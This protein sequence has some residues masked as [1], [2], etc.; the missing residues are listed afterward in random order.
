MC[1]KSHQH[2]RYLLSVSERWI[3]RRYCADPLIVMRVT[4]TVDIWCHERACRSPTAVAFL[5]AVAGSESMAWGTGCMCQI[6]DTH[7]R[8]RHARTCVPF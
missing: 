2:F 3:N 6:A 5:V 1:C 8:A 4:V 7:V